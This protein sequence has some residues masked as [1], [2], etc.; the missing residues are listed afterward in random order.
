MF[1]KRRGRRD[2]P[3]R[4]ERPAVDA[5]ALAAIDGH[6]VATGRGGTPCG[7]LRLRRVRRVRCAR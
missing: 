1:L 3:V 5:G 7:G 2:C 4:S 6:E